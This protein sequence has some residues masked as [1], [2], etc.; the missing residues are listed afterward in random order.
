MKKDLQAQQTAAQ[1]NNYNNGRNERPLHIIYYSI[2]L[3]DPLFS[4]LDMPSLL[5]QIHPYA[6]YK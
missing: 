4:F 3:L 1:R 6:S 2:N 5:F